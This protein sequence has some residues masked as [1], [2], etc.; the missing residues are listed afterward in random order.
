MSAKKKIIRQK[1]RDAVLKRDRSKCVICKT[2]EGIDVHHITDRTL[3]PG[4]GYV[5]ENGIS[6]CAEHLATAEEYH[7]SNGENCA[8]G[9]TPKALYMKI[10]SNYEKALEASKRIEGHG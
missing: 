4:G 3:M 10:G 1:F 2:S 5:R 9:F 8:D 7:L 6:L